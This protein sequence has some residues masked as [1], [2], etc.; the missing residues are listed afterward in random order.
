MK[1]NLSNFKGVSI[2][3][4]DLKKIIGGGSSCT[5]CGQSQC[6]G[7]CGTGSGGSCSWQKAMPG[8]GLEA[9]CICNHAPG[10]TQ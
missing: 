5:D 10:G 9:G 4:N 2:S 6:S 7:P 1:N 3:R 8:L